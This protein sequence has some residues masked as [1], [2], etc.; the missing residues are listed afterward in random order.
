MKRLLITPFADNS[1]CFRGIDFSSE[2]LLI[3]YGGSLPERE[4]SFDDIVYRSE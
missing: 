1:I 3:K 2:I 4:M